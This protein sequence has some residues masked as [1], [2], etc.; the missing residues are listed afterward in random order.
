MLP[1]K[2]DE[3]V[4]KRLYR[5]MVVGKDSKM[6]RH[7]TNWTLKGPSGNVRKGLE[8][9]GYPAGPLK[10]LATSTYA[11][12]VPKNPK[13][14]VRKELTQNVYPRNQTASVR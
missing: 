1:K 5:K 7:P 3:H 9:T 8:Q 13:G 10:V 11:N 12:W 6:N 14:N 2:R 4:R